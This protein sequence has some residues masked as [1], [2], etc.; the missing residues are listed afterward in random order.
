M[1]I[2]VCFRALF[3]FFFSYASLLHTPLY[4]SPPPT[5]TSCFGQGDNSWL[6]RLLFHHL[7]SHAAGKVRGNSWLG[8][9]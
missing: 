4:A 9:R 2:Q 6:V 8:E 3:L 7:A 5:P 1:F